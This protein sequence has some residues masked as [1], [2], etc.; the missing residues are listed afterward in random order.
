MFLNGAISFTEVPFKRLHATADTHADMKLLTR[1]SSVL[2]WLPSSNW[3]RESDGESYLFSTSIYPIMSSNMKRRE[4]WASSAEVSEEKVENL[5]FIPPGQALL[6][7]GWDFGLCSL[8]R[9]LIAYRFPMNKAI[10]NIY[11][12]S[13]RISTF[14]KYVFWDF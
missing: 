13:Q 3:C 1:M 6:G 11:A 8:Q 4:P 7:W 12:S 9:C 10:P 5:C 2:Q 14:G